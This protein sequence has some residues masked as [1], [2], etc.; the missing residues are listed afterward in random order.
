MIAQMPITFLTFLQSHYP[1]PK[2]DLQIIA[3]HLSTRT[4][5][6]KTILLREGATAQEMFFI[7][8]GILKIVTNNEKG[9]A[10]TQFFLKENQFCTILDSFENGVAAQESIVAAIDCELV[11]LQKQKLLR[12]YQQL[13]YL[14]E[15]I[16]N[17]TRR[18]LLAKI[19]VRNAYMGE[20]AAS[21][22]ETFLARQPEIALRV[23][24]G[25]VASYLGIAQQSL[26]RIRRN[27]R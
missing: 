15:L 12:L 20:N 14:K 11:V 4:V 1:I 2:S 24:L 5:E 10:V 13:P 27:V 9:N 23:P 26:S 16:Q 19:A 17:I 7:C 18:A 6:A 25:D 21:R 3:N 8:E 22:Y